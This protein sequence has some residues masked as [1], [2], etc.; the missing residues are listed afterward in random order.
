M[1]AH[2]PAIAQHF[3]AQSHS[4]RCTSS[5]GCIACA[6]ER[7]LHRVLSTPSSTKALAPSELVARLRLVDASIQV[8]RPQDV[9]EVWTLLQSALDRD[10][11][12]KGHAAASFTRSVFSGELRN[13]LR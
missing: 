13:T 12:T 11:V 9:H 4:Q 2:T 7:H 8:G 3:A 6:L 1:L 5:G 10:E